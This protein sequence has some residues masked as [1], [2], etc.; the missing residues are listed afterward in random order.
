MEY[1][2]LDCERAQQAFNQIDDPLLGEYYQS[3]ID[4]GVDT[5]LKHDQ[6]G[7]YIVASELIAR[8]FSILLNIPVDKTRQSGRDMVIE[9]VQVLSQNTNRAA[10]NA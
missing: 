6:S 10:N 4:I 9:A 5:A 8:A 3:A 1:T 2:L 7:G